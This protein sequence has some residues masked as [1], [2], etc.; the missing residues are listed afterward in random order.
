MEPPLL[1]C[2]AS[3]A[4]VLTTYEPSG[5]IVS[6]S[7]T[8]PLPPPGTIDIE[9]EKD[10]LYPFLSALFIFFISPAL[11]GNGGVKTPSPDANLTGTKPP[12][13]NPIGPPP[14][15][16]LPLPPPPFLPLPEPGPRVGP[17]I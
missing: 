2:I 13:A 7:S 6:K 14:A 8:F 1:A 11:A 15:A 5:T 4:S 3:I 16:F 12:L 17:P 9:P 10:G